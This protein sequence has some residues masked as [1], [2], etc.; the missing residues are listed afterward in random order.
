MSSTHRRLPVHVLKPGALMMIFIIGGGYVSGREVAEFAGE[1][2]PLGAVSVASIAVGFALLTVPVFEFARRFETR[3]YAD[4]I[5]ALLGRAWP[6]FDALFVLTALFLVGV[7]TSFA[8]VFM[9]VLLA[10]YAG[11][12]IPDLAAGYHYGYLVLGVAVLALVG[13]GESFITDFDLVGS[14]VVM[15]IFLLFTVAVLGTGGRATAAVDAFSASVDSYCATT[16]R[17]ES[18]VPST[19]VAG[20]VYVGIHVPVY[21]L[22]IGELHDDEEGFL[23]ETRRQ[24]VL[25]GAFAGVCMTAPFAL[26]YAV[27]MGFYPDPSVVG[28]SQPVPWLPMLERSVGTWGV[29]LYVVVAAWGFLAT[30]TALVGTVVDRVG[31]TVVGADRV[32]DGAGR[33]VAAAAVV[34]AGLAVASVGFVR[35]IFSYYGWFALVYGVVFAAPMLTAGVWRLARHD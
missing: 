34:V 28:G 27:Q 6:A 10:T 31:G 17:C 9:D 2:G 16:P 13:L 14:A 1:Y 20:L 19:L 23:L 8:G 18:S 4:F 32:A 30:T 3:T 25:A 12:T 35:L 22:I 11:V 26:T 29:A 5:R 15:A 24:S 7:V 33:L 21:P